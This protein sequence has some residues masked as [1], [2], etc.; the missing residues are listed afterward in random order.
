MRGERR[1]AGSGATGNQAAVSSM[2][3]CAFTASA[4]ALLLLPSLA[5]AHETAM[6]PGAHSKNVRL[7]AKESRKECLKLAA[8]QRLA[9]V[10]TAQQTAQFNI[11]YPAGDKVSYPVRRNVRHLHGEY[12]SRAAQD[13]C[14]MWTNPHAVGIN[15]SY[16]FS[17]RG[18]GKS[19]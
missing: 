6:P 18:G 3:F 4:A 14:M 13:Y 2:M 15:L 17:V 5:A 7:P 1:E 10:F 11:H 8:G 16:S 9:Y 19:K 12:T